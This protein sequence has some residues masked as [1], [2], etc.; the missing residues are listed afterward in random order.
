MAFP[1]IG[2]PGIALTNPA[3]YPTAPAGSAFTPLYSNVVSLAAAETYLIPAGTYYLKMGGYTMVQFL[4]PVTTQWRGLSTTW[5]P[6]KPI[7]SDGGNFRLAN[8]TGTPISAMITNAGSGY[9]NGIGTTATGLTVTAST[10]SSVWVPVVGGAVSTTAVSASGGSGYT[11]AP[12]VVVSTPPAGGLPATATCTISSGAVNA[13]TITNQGAG[14]TSP[15]TVGPTLT[16]V[17]DPRDTSGSGASWTTVL[18]GSGSLTA[19]YP[20]NNGTALTAAPTF[21][22]SPAS[23]TAATA[24]MNFCVTAYAVS[25][26]GTTYVAPVVVTSGSNLVTGTPIYTNPLY[27]KGV[28]QPR[29]CRINA[30]LGTTTVTPVGQIVE[31]NGAGIQTVPLPVIQTSS[32]PTIA[33]SASL[34]FA[35]GGVSDTSYIQGI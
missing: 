25:A 7:E 28:I 2:G 35:V 23:S 31:D 10:G 20:S 12:T 32:Y 26:P 11:Y 15:T 22:F 1:R 3:N 8:L 19:L 9:T 27:E 30:A 34:T 14:Y 5:D 4:D 6:N 18:S 33:N 13:V 29:P 16:F 17:N 24:V 21:T